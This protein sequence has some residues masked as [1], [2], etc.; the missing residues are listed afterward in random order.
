MS[1]YPISGTFAPKIGRNTTKKCSTCG[2]PLST[3]DSPELHLIGFPCSMTH[4]AQVTREE[5]EK[6][7]VHVSGV[8]GASGL[9]LYLNDYRVAGGK[10]W[11]GGT[12]VF[13]KTFKLGDYPELMQL[14][15]TYTQAKVLEARITEKR[16][17][18][19]LVGSL[20]T[21]QMVRDELAD[22]VIDLQAERSN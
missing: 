18:Y 3:E 1:N 8:F 15:D 6:F 7:E 20:E 5:L 13:E 21:P 9:C 10:P 16:H 2:I 22:E 19:A 12:S 11:G 17:A 14:I 4:P